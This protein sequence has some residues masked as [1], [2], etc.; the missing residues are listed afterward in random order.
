MGAD[1]GHLLY[2]L[3]MIA[4]RVTRHALVLSHDTED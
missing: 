3:A 4:S 2:K 1:G